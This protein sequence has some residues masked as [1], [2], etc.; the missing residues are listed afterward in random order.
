MKKGVQM[1]AIRSLAEKDMELALKTVS[2]I[3]YEGVEF[4][5]FYN[6]TPEEITSWLKKYN[7]EVMGAH[8]APE[9]IFDEADKTIAFHKSIGNTRIICPW[10]DLKTKADV[11]V[12]AEKMK[13]VASKYKENGMKLYYHNHDHEFVKA[14]GE[15][16]IDILADE[17]PA[18]ILSL[19]FDVYW[20][21]RGGECP[22]GYFKKYNDRVDIFHAKDGIDDKGV[23]LSKGAVD[24][25]GVFE[26]AKAHNM[27]WAVVESEACEEA[28]DQVNAITED[29]AELL[30][31]L[32]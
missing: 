2:E 10:Y 23:T 21:Y 15:Y 19:E 16:L 30:K 27:E 12:L 14:D 1:Y 22:V 13:S 8:I 11:L 17:V 9:L 4:A 24:M 28:D 18:D 29:Y 26:Y 3:G 20:V 32:A 25:T 6:H 7:L 5:S 31:L